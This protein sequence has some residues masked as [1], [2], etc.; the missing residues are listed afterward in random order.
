MSKLNSMSSLAN[1]MV[2]WSLLGHSM[3]ANKHAFEV[4]GELRQL[5]SVGSFNKFIAGTNMLNFSTFAIH[6]AWS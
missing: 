6:D 4:H 3:A 1:P 2:S 5:H